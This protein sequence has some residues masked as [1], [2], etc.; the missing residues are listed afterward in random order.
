MR[1]GEA[2][3]DFGDAKVA[4]YGLVD[5]SARLVGI[6]EVI[7]RIGVIGRDPHDFGPSRCRTFD[8]APFLQDD[9]EIVAIAGIRRIAVRGRAQAFACDFTVAV[10]IGDEAKELQRLRRRRV[11]KRPAEPLR[12]DQIAAQKMSGGFGQDI[13]GAGVAPRCR[14]C[15]CHPCGEKP[16]TR[17]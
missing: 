14:L 4:A 16:M 7:E 15:H 11:D 10:A 2:R 6:G 5:P 9:A 13:G 17:Q 8:V 12:F 1:L 3:I